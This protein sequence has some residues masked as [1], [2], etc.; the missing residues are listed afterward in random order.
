M[1]NNIESEKNKLLAQVNQYKSNL[2][3]QAHLIKEKFQDKG[4]HIAIVGGTLLAGWIFYKIFSVSNK[5]NPTT[6]LPQNTCTPN[7]ATPFVFVPP[8]QEPLIVRLIKENITMFLL[9]IAKE[10]LTKL[11]E[12]L[13]QEA[14]QETQQAEVV[15]DQDEDDDDQDA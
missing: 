5:N 12:Q 7:Q 10:K 13:R 14:Q 4:V 1:E 9:A 6:L 8:A 2:K 11:F 15:E 3:Q